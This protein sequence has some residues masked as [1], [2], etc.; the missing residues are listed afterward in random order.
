MSISSQ[1]ENRRPSRRQILVLTGFTFVFIVF[2]SSF[3]II[4]GQTVPFTTISRGDWL[5]LRGGADY[6]THPELTKPVL[7]VIT[8]PQDVDM[9]IEFLDLQPR[10]LRGNRAVGQEI[11]RLRQIDY[12]QVCVVVVFQGYR[13]ST[14]HGVTIEYITGSNNRLALH[15]RF[16]ELLPGEGAGAMVTDPYHMIAI[17]KTEIQDQSVVFEIWNGIQL[18]ATGT[19][20]ISS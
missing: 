7:F 12:S 4:R 11:D 20:I 10:Q 18:V 14:N 17:P 16:K 19:P 5:A 1:A 6:V 15:T 13:G 3:F 9:F 2:I 8:N